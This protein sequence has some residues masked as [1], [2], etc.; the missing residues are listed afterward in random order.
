MKP[1][2]TWWRRFSRDE[3]GATAIEYAVMLSLIAVAVIA[4]VGQVAT[5][6]KNSFDT[7]GEAVNAALSP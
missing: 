6:T 7:S 5:A 1:L 3:A 4:S 2:Q